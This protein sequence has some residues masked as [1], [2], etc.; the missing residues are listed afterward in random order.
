[1]VVQEVLVRVD[2][3]PMTEPILKV[4]MCVGVDEGGANGAVGPKRFLSQLRRFRPTGWKIHFLFLFILLGVAVGFKMK[5]KKIRTKSSFI[6]SLFQLVAGGCFLGLHLKKESRSRK[7]KNVSP[8]FR[9][10]LPPS[11]GSECTL[12]SPASVLCS[13]H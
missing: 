10:Q 8:A 7:T 4:T 11:K 9:P 1:M 3:W 6:L 13:I 12:G 2:L 5:K